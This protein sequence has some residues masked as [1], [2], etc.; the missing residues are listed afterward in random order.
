MKI[1][2]NSLALVFAL[3]PLAACQSA[4][5]E[6]DQSKDTEESWEDA[7]DRPPT[8]RTMRIY[9]QVLA[10]SGK[11]EESEYTLRRTIYEYPEFLPAYID[12]AELCMRQ[13]RVAD[14]VDVL[15]SAQK[16]V[17][18]DPVVLNDLGMCAM[19]EDRTVEALGW[20]ERAVEKA[21]RE[22]R[23]QSNVAVA[24]GRLGRYEEALSVYVEGIGMRPKDA[25]HNVAVLCESRGDFEQ[26][27]EYY[28]LAGSNEDAERARASMQAA[29]KE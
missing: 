4:P 18:D 2:L 20:F 8:P 29:V 6:K 25:Y 13:D 12:L 14:A 27:A 5:A 19:L 10:N 17:P 26:A 15:E 11:D 7:K 21:P 22:A 16:W 3:V 24:L 1:Q 9:A 28:G 23:Y